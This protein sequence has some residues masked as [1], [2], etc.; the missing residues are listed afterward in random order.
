MYNAELDQRGAGPRSGL[1]IGLYEGGVVAREDRQKQWGLEASGRAE[2]VV[3]EQAV[4]RA[5]EQLGSRIVLEP[6]EQGWI[7]RFRPGMA[8]GLARTSPTASISVGSVADIEA[9]MV[10]V[11]VA[12]VES[13]T[14]EFNPIATFGLITVSRRML[15]AGQYQKFL[16]ALAKELQS[17]GFEVRKQGSW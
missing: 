14:K 7:A 2:R 10:S 13:V 1:R 15:G 12:V 4:G 8:A 9:S 11:K 6:A 5:S 17:G 3:V 16:G